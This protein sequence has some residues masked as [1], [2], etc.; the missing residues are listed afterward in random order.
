MASYYLVNNYSLLGIVSGGRFRPIIKRYS[1]N[2]AHI[3]YLVYYNGGSYAEFKYIAGGGFSSHYPY[4]FNVINIYGCVETNQNITDTHKVEILG[5][6]YDPTDIIYLNSDSIYDKCGFVEGVARINTP[7][8]DAACIVK[9]GVLYPVIT[10]FDNEID[11]HWTLPNVWLN[12]DY[13]V[14][15][16]QQMVDKPGQYLAYDEAEA[17]SHWSPVENYLHQHVNMPIV[18]KVGYIPPTEIGVGTQLP[19]LNYVVAL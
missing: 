16:L 2:G 11:D 14:A 3:E 4:W 12:G 9:N 1:S 19:G 7:V 5:S 10:E 17:E 18:P 6:E 13:E 15:N 8:G